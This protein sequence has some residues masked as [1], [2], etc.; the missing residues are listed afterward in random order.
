M[1]QKGHFCCQRCALRALR[2]YPPCMREKYL[3]DSISNIMINRIVNSIIIYLIIVL[4]AT[5]ATR[6]AATFPKRVPISFTPKVFSQERSSALN[7]DNALFLLNS[8]FPMAK[9]AST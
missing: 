1:P 5:L 8:I 7:Q 6:N 3:L 2:K 4:K 9:R